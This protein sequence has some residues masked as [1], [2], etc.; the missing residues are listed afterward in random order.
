VKPIKSTAEILA[1]KALNRDIDDCWI[2]WAIDMIT[3]GFETEH[4]IIL[5]G[6][7]R[8]FNQFELQALT[9]RALHEL[10]LDY[11]DLDKTIKNYVCFLIEK[12]FETES[13]VL[14][15]LSMLKDLS[16]ELDHKDYLYDFYLLHF[17]KEDLNYS[18]HQWYWD[19]VD[20]NN[21]DTIIHEHLEKWRMQCEVDFKTTTHKIGFPPT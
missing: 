6:E 15:T 2:T 3:A 19:V 13:D 20:R 8:P 5:A 10:Q 7:T 16:L 21:I 18:N 12:V 14:E 11:S 4:L 9:S 1:F 17:A